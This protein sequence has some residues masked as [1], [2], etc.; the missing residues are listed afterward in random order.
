MAEQLPRFDGLTC[1]LGET[2]LRR[3]KQ[4][5]GLKTQDD[6]MQQ[7]KGGAKGS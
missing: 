6:A 5:Y 7:K 2:L 1:V 4:G 3:A